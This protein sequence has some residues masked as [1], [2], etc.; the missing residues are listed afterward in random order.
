VL[1]RCLYTCSLD[2]REQRLADSERS[3]RTRHTSSHDIPN[4]D[5]MQPNSRT[6]GAHVERSSPGPR[7]TATSSLLKTPPSTVL[8]RVVLGGNDNSQFWMK[9]FYCQIWVFTAQFRESFRE[10]V[11]PACRRSTASP[12]ARGT[13]SHQF[14]ISF[15]LLP[16]RLHNTL[17]TSIPEPSQTYL[18]ASDTSL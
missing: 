16:S 13:Y 2:T 12:E 5:V 7:N 8:A 1:D 9:A 3:C 15:V 4:W 6:S 11:K 18:H 14:P 10:L 17:A